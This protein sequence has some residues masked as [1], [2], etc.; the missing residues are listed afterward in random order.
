M[1]PPDMSGEFT[2]DVDVERHLIRITMT[3]FFH[4]SDI[5]RFIH[6]RTAAYARLRSAPNQNLTLVDI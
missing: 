6:A 1:H 5:A 3:G 2:S 4:S